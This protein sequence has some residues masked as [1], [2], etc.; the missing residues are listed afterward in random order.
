MGLGTPRT[1]HALLLSVSF[2]PW[3]VLGQNIHPDENESGENIHPDESESG[4]L[5][6]KRGVAKGSLTN[7][8]RPDTLFTACRYKEVP[9][10]D[11]DPQTLM[12]RKTV[13]LIVEEDSG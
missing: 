10:S 3:T 5:R 7:K 8:S 11:C 2:F 1:F 6:I 4:S 12:R 9:W 13:Q